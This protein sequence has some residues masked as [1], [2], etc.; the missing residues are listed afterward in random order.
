MVAGPRSRSKSRCSDPCCM[1]YGLRDP[2]SRARSCRSCM[3]AR[4]RNLLQR[5]ERLAP[6]VRVD[7]HQ[8]PPRPHPWVVLARGQRHGE[9][10]RARNALR[11]H[12]FCSRCQRLAVHLLSSTR[13]PP[14]ALTQVQLSRWQ[15]CTHT[16][17]HLREVIFGHRKDAGHC[18]APASRTSLALPP[19]PFSVPRREPHRARVRCRRA[20][21]ASDRCCAPIA[22]R[23]TAAE[24]METSS[25]V[26]VLLLLYPLSP[27]RPS[28][29]ASRGWNSFRSEFRGGHVASVSC[30]AITTVPPGSFATLRTGHGRARRACETLVHNKGRRFAFWYGAGISGAPNLIVC[31]AGKAR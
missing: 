22:Q 27:S 25:A 10:L 21:S 31:E 19:T 28:P 17:R 26:L 29:I 8:L 24:P 12:F 2:C 30:L 3:P 18:K 7:G 15:L 16:P 1:P 4:L 20:R 9:P 13:G 23:C 14:P 6:V 5:H 11:Q